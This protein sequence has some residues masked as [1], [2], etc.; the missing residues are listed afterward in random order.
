MGNFDARDD[1]IDARSSVVQISAVQSVI[2]QLHIEVNTKLKFENLFGNQALNWS[3]NNFDEIQI[4]EGLDW[5]FFFSVPLSSLGDVPA[6][7]SFFD[8][9]GTS[10][11]I[12]LCHRQPNN[13]I[14]IQGRTWL[15]A[16]ILATTIFFM[17]LPIKPYPF[18]ACLAT[19]S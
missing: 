9:D 10:F 1:A 13:Y 2:F 17:A 19:S 16:S 18:A 6:I 5:T 4:S 3:K 7:F 8:I 11:S 12:W 14:S 15:L